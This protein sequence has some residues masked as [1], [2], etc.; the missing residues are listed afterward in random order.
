MTAC[1]GGGVVSTVCL[2]GHPTTHMQNS[3]PVLV[4]S[5]VNQ[6]QFILESPDWRKFGPAF[7]GCLHPSSLIPHPSSLIPHPSFVTP[8]CVRRL[9]ATTLVAACAVASGANG[10]KAIGLCRL[11]SKIATTWQRNS[12]S[13]RS[14]AASRA[15]TAAIP[16]FSAPPR[17]A[18]HSTISTARRG[19]PAFPRS[20][21]PPV[22]Q[23]NGASRLRRPASSFPART[24]RVQSFAA[25][26]PPVS[27]AWFRWG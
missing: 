10:S 26:V 22:G 23:R 4:P 21:S 8:P 5:M 19:V 14:R 15:G 12:T 1:H 9:R 7:E 3:K 27:G 20:I 11:S 18:G 24:R 13:R 16:F 25:Y 6:R 2:A 17:P